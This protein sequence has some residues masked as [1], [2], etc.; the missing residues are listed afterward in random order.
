MSMLFGSFLLVVS[1]ILELT[2]NT[3]FEIVDETKMVPFYQ[4]VSIHQAIKRNLYNPV[5]LY[6]AEC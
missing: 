2:N 6:K 1:A 4:I 5:I 3:M